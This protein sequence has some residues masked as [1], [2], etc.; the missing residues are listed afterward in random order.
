[1]ELRNLCYIEGINRI[2]VVT[3]SRSVDGVGL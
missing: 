2:L 1:M 3:S